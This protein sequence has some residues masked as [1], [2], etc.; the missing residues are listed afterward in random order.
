MPVIA[1][2]DPGAAGFT[3]TAMVL[4]GLVPQVFWAVTPIL[5]FSPGDPVVTVIDIVPCPDVITHPD[6]TDQ[7]YVVAFGTELMLYV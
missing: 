1:P 6:G 4:A 7:L 3:V 5:P 2:G